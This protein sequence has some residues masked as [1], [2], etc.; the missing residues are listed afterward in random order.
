MFRKTICLMFVLS[1]PAAAIAQDSYVCAK[2]KPAERF[3]A[4]QA[5]VEDQFGALVLD[6][7]GV[8][9]MCGATTSSSHPDVQQV[10]YKTKPAK[11][12]VQASFER[13]DHTLF[14]EFGEH[15]LSLVKPAGI[16]VA[17][18]MVHG[19]GGT[20]TTD[21]TGVDHFQCYKAARAKGSVK[22]APPF[23]FEVEDS[24]GTK[25]I[26]VTKIAKICAPI[27]LNG[28]NPDAPMHAP[29]L[30][31]Y[32]ARL[33]VGQIGGIVSVNNDAFGGG[34]MTLK[35]MTEYCVPA[36]LDSMP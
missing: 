26:S 22:F 36:Y 35:S 32:R 28:E 31:C 27:V 1:A 9:L 19:G 6:V 8:G 34:A 30:A 2:A 18:A 33:K 7:R 29:H 3:T 21:T 23:P 10:S 16:L 5:T 13:S 4:V 17:S 25:T 15:S 24:F 12:V 11:D 14:D 20:G